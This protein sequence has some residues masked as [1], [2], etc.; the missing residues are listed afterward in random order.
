MT[1]GQLEK[2]IRTSCA[3]A[4]QLNLIASGLNNDPLEHLDQAEEESYQFWSAVLRDNPDP[5]SMPRN[6]TD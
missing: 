6:E 5:F 1:Y 3:M 2:L 4:D